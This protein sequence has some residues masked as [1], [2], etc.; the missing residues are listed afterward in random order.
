MSQ[1]KNNL[2]AG[3]AKRQWPVTL[4]GCC[5]YKDLDVSTSDLTTFIL[6]LSV[7][8]IR[9]NLDCFQRFARLR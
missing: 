3:D 6:Q 7:G 1:N 2:L 5:S 9:V 8:F 4:C